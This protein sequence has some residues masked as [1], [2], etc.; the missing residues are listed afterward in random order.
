MYP[1][2]LSMSNKILAHA[3]FRFHGPSRLQQTWYIDFLSHKFEII[4]ILI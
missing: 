1:H 3:D 4:G 2:L